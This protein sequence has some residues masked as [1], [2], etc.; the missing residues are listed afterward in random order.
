MFE[1]KGYT[2]LE[3]IKNTKHKVKCIDKDGYLYLASYDMVRDKRTKKLD[4]FKRQNPFKAYNMRLK[5]SEM[6]ENCTILTTDEEIMKFHGPNIKLTFVCPKCGKSY[7]KKW[8]HW[9]QQN[10]NCHFCQECS[11]KESSYEF[12][13]KQW[14][15][16]HDI[17]YEREY[18]FEDCRDIR[19]LPFDFMI[20]LNDN[21][22]LI[23]TDGCQHYYK[24]DM[25][26]NFT[27]EERKKKD[28][29]KNRY[30]KEHGYTLLRIPYWDFSRDTY[31]KKLNKTFF[32]MK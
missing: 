1:E 28:S 6:Q 20:N 24:N 19:V 3:E 14:L 9:L 25:F 8:C 30:C 22:I 15:E 11:R 13:V 16:G 18:W 21:I 32:G 7:Q 5:A 12:L 10:K 27:L 4:P 31:I 17:P 26:N 23:E 29:I 2:V